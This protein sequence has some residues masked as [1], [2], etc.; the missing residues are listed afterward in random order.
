MQKN[1]FVGISSGFLAKMEKKG[2]DDDWGNDFEITWD[3]IKRLLLYISR[4]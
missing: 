1:F 4:S 3:L 2:D